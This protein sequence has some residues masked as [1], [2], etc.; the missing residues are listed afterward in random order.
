MDLHVFKELLLAIFLGLVQGI[1]EFLPISSTAHLRLV[2]EFLVGKDIGLS[3][4]NIVQ[5]GTLM[6]I[7]Q[8]FWADLKNLYQHLIRVLTSKLELAQCWQNIRTWWAGKNDFQDQAKADLDILLAQVVLATL[9]IVVFALLMRQQV[10]LLR[11]NILYIALFLLAGGVLIMLSEWVHKHRLNQSKTDKMAPWEVLIIG[12]CQCLSVFP[13]ISRSGATLSGALFLGRDRQT[14]VRF[15]FLL[16]IPALGLAGIYDLVKV[17]KEFLTGEQILL[18][19]NAQTWSL[20][21]I[22][23]SIVSLVVGFLT[24]YIFGLVCLRWLLQ[25]LA[26]NRASVF[27]VYRL[28]LASVIILSVLW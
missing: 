25:Y 21:Y 17:G 2:S 12:C 14:S 13:G 23:L 10:E 24:A 28:I 15:S 26:T 9:P 6:A 18:W 3:A 20:D 11:Q 19:P 1:T 4:S 22:H 16:S 8:Y 5:A 7:I 27:V